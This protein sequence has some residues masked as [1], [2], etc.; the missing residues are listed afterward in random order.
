MKLVD[1]A[2]NDLRR[3]RGKAL[4]L[5]LGLAVGITTV[6]ALQAITHTLRADVEVKLDE[7]GANILIVPRSNTLSLSYGGL[8]VSAAAY[9]VG[10]LTERDVG[11][12]WTIPFSRN[13]SIVAPK[14]LSAVEIA[15]QTVLVAGVDF[16]SELELKKWW[17]LEGRAPEADDEA[18]VGA[19]V[20]SLLGLDM[21]SLVQVGNGT[22]RIVAVLAENGTQDD[23][24]LFIDLDAARRVLGRP[25]SVSLIEV[26]ALCSACPVE[27]IVKQIE[28]VLPQARVSAL[29][30]AVTLRM[31]TVEQLSRFSLL[32]SGVVLFIGGLVVLTTMMGAVSERRQEIGLF[33]AIG[34]RG[35]HIVRIIL[36]EAALLSVVGGL[37]GWLVGMAAAVLLAPGIARADI[38]VSWD[39]WLAVGAVGLALIVGL[40]ASLYPAV[41]AAR[42]DP[43]TALRSL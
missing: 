7:Y 39:P 33:R 20:A 36:T 18:V 6:V 19:R 26:A 30:Q 42:L 3:R 11:L 41:R 5:V 35:A 23:D 4:L 29:R 15:D 40:L 28:A 31:E 22:F 13:L 37:L 2:W 8:T 10:E 12:L 21:G 34:F 17:R 25:G 38:A 32:L 14:L 16:A 24:I 43:T 27:E 1:I 9:D